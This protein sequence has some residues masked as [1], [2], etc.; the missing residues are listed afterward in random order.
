[1]VLWAAALGVTLCP[2]PAPVGCV[3][4]PP[5][6]EGQIWHLPARARASLRW[7]VDGRVVAEDELVGYGEDLLRVA[8]VLEPTGWQHALGLEVNLGGVQVRSATLDPIFCPF[9]LILHGFRWHSEGVEVRLANQGPGPSPR[10][11]VR[12]SINSV[13]HSDQV[14][15]SLPAGGFADL[16]LPSAA[17]RLLGEALVATKGQVRK[18]RGWVPVWVTLAVRPG[19]LDLEG[20]H[21][22][23][24]FLVG[25]AH[26]RQVR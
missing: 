2:L 16:L 6:V 7:S 21:K 26:L 4:V 9:Y 12:W 19:P 24:Q 10:V 8:M 25:Y 20:P 14:M 3:P 1:M 15:D 18:G 22:T 13:P 11:P 23:W 5:V 17:N